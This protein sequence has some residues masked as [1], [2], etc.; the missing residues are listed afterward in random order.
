MRWLESV[1]IQLY[2]SGLWVTVPSAGINETAENKIM[3]T[4]FIRHRV[5]NYA[6]WKK[7]FEG[8]LP[9]RRAGGEQ[10]Y[11]IGNIPGKTNNLCLL[12]QWD[13]AA[14]ASKFLKSKE[15]KAAME[16]ATV[17]EPPETFIFEEKEKG[18]TSA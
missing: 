11:R 4:V 12:F 15:L 17:S 3:V 1:P 16:A 18:K 5:K 2:R 6:K 14:N 10:S 8:F 9:Q 7:A 13:S